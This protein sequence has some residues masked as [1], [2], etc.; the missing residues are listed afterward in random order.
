MS[1]RILLPLAAALSL[2]MLAAAVVFQARAREELAESRD[3]MARAAERLQ[4][5][6]D[7]L[8]REQEP[9]AF[10]LFDAR[11][12][13]ARVKDELRA[14]LHDTY[15][16]SVTAFDLA[17]HG[18]DPDAALAHLGRCP[19]ELRGW[20]WDRRR[21]VGELLLSELEA[22]DGTVLAL[23]L[24]AD[25]T[26][27]ASASADATVTLWTPPSVDAD[28][29][30][31][32]H[33]DDVLDVAL[34]RDGAWVATGSSD[35]TVRLWSFDE[36]EE[37]WVGE[38][39]LGRV[40]AVAF[41]PAGTRVAS[42]SS[43]ATVRV[44]ERATG[45]LEHELEGHGDGVNDV[46][47]AADGAYVV[48][49]SDD[50]DVRLWSTADGAEHA[51]L[52]EH[53]DWVRAVAVD[54]T[55]DRRFVTG[56][57]DERLLTWELDDEG[58]A[59]LADVRSLG[60]SLA[61]LSF[62]PAGGLWVATDD[63]AIL[64]LAHVDGGWEER[65]RLVR[66]LPSDDVVS[67]GAR[68][69]FCGDDELV[70][71]WTAE[72]PEPT[73]SFQAAPGR[74]VRA[75]VAND[76]DTLLVTGGSDRMVRLWDGSTGELLRELEGHRREVQALALSPFAELLA[77]GS[78]DREVLLWDVRTGEQVGR[79]EDCGAAIEGLAFTKEGEQLVAVLSNG[80]QRV[81]DVERRELVHERPGPASGVLAAVLTPGRDA[82]WAAVGG[83]VRAW[84][85]LTGERV[86]S[87]REPALGLVNSLAADRYTDLVA[88]GSDSGELF[89]WGRSDGEPVLRRT[90]NV[91]GRPLALA[92]DPEGRRLVTGS[93]HGVLQV[94]NRT[95][96]IELLRVDLVPGADDTEIEV[97]RFSADGARLY[98]ADRMGRVFV[99][100]SD[101]DAW[102]ETR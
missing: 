9:Y 20:E 11:E 44:W 5:E 35:E 42:V 82:L 80:S 32:G 58:S 81:W 50:G 85:P 94:W 16:A 79:F 54:P 37:A 84:A 48:S 52:E 76:D 28:D 7:R 41:D 65:R 91:A 26:R 72:P 63:G 46:A 19:V 61:A 38:G 97:V 64:G 101:L 17:R 86:F 70:R 87:A 33:E 49:V 30:L 31:V 51:V 25:G 92:F 23:A 24:S 66:E 55:D 6:V 98:C 100:E 29:Y 8:R 10:E 57:D 69:A 12:E 102:L 95:G 13:A 62:D 93:S 40:W 34:S 59:R 89:V 83:V 90:T 22:H 53:T 99:L 75:L 60:A 47:F 2:A 36:A 43:D 77:S 15:F 21:L 3:A 78:R 1:G 18:P 74:A 4:G 14:A 27:L 39:H 96:T 56:G 67:D 71:L 45:A 68:V 88:A 73:W